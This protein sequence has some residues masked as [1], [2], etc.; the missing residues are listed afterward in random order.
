VDNDPIDASPILL[1]LYASSSANEISD[2]ENTFEAFQNVSSFSKEPIGSQQL[3]APGGM[4]G[5]SR[6]RKAVVR[7]K[8][9]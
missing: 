9:E 8:R 3:V 7:K 2:V 5:S 6:E 4:S 1:V